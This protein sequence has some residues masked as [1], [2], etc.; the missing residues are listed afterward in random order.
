MKTVHMQPGGPGENGAAVKLPKANEEEIR[1]RF[2]EH[3]FNIMVSE[4]ISLN[5][6]VPDFRAP[7][8]V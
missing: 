8:L 5:R 7:E 2:K 4:A 6:S 3:E 1:E